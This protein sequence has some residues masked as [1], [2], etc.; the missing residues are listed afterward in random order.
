MVKVQKLGLWL[1]L[2]ATSDDAEYVVDRI[3]GYIDHDAVKTIDDLEIE[4][5][6]EQREYEWVRKTMTEILDVC[7]GKD[8]DEALKILKE[9]FYG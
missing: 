5:K 7:K 6:R 4:Y 9:K 1:C 3:T 2:I 8:P